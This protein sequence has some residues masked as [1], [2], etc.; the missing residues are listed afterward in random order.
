MTFQVGDR[1]RIVAFPEQP[2]T[3]GEIVT[4]IEVRPE[5]EWPYWVRFDGRRWPDSC[6]TAD[7]LA[8]VA[9]NDE[10]HEEAVVGNR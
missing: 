9:S 7:E 2:Q 8:R 3:V 10:D 1:V 4:V 6:L 5:S